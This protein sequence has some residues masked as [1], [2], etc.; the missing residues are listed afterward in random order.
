MKLRSLNEFQDPESWMKSRLASTYDVGQQTY[1]ILDP[2]IQVPE[3][4]SGS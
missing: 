1:E 2:E 4:H 3:F